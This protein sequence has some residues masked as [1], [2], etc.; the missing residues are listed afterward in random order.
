MKATNKNVLNQKGGFFGNVLDPLMKAALR[1]MK[2]VLTSL[3]KGVLIPSGLKK[4]ASATDAA[5]QKKNDGLAM[6]TLVMSNEKM[7]DIMKI[8]KY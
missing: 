7:E 6:T 1:L 2:N 5:I 4:A 8:V 3:A